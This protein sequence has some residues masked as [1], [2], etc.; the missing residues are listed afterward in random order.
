[1]RNAK[2]P[3]RLGQSSGEFGERFRALSAAQVGSAAWL[4]R[5]GAGIARGRLVVVLPGSTRAVT[6]ALDELLIPE[7]GH[8]ARLLGRLE[9][10]D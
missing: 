4:S 6:L 3:F 8:V 10:G 1:M 9:P 2:L 5:A 7:L